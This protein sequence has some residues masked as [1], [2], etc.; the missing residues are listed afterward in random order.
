MLDSSEA[1]VPPLVDQCLR[2]IKTREQ[3]IYLKQF[4]TIRERMFQLF[5]VEKQK[6][7]LDEVQLR[8]PSGQIH[9]HIHY[10]DGK[11]HGEYRVWGRNGITT[12]LDNYSHGVQHGP[13]TFWRADGRIW[14]EC[15]Y[16]RGKI[17]STQY[18]Y[19]YVCE[20]QYRC[21]YEGKACV[22]KTQIIKV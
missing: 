5:D 20:Q 19:E 3:L 4:E 13:S 1:Y 14:R 2:L 8:Y 9:K 16:T 11:L 17:D 22:S 10:L 21:V 6:R 12:S 7:D 15:T 18:V